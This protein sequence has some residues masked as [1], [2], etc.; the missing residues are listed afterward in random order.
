MNIKLTIA[1]AVTEAARLG[2]L[3]HYERTALY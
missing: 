2:V 1:V 3:K